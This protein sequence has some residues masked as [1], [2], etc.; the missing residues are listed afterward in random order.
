MLQVV[1]EWLQL[2]PKSVGLWQTCGMKEFVAA[3][4]KKRSGECVWRIHITILSHTYFNRHCGEPRRDK[5]W[6]I[7]WLNRSCRIHWF[8]K[9]F[10]NSWLDGT[11]QTRCQRVACRYNWNKWSFG[12]GRMF[13]SCRCVYRIEWVI[14]MIDSGRKWRKFDI[15]L[16]MQWWGRDIERCRTEI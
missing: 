2:I 5:I 8:R 12:N 4:A 6:R 14:V 15:T 3:P 1:V 11:R 16:E 9:I 10:G 13:R 7:G